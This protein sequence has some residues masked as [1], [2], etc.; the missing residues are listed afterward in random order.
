MR[1]ATSTAVAD[2]P[3]DIETDM[4]PE[5]FKRITDMLAQRQLDCMDRLHARDAC[6]SLTDIE[7]GYDFQGTLQTH[8]P[9]MLAQRQLDLTVC[10]EEVHKPQTNLAAIRCV[11]P[12]PSAFTGRTRSGPRAGSTSV[13]GAARPRQPELGGRC[14]CIRT[15]AARWL[16][17]K[18][19]PGMQILATHLSDSSVDFRAIDY[20][21][22]TPSWWA[23]E[24]HGIGRKRRWPWPITISSSPWWA[25]CSP[26]RLGGR[27]SHPFY[28]AI[29]ASANWL[30]APARLSAQFGRAEHHLVGGGYPVYAQP[31]KE[32]E[33][34]Y[35]QLGP[36]GEILADERWWQQMQ[37]T[38]KWVGRTTGRDDGDGV[39]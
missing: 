28:E 30:A 31:C 25:W 17:S 3:H 34:P 8:F 33:M 32:K 5:R 10:M 12:T 4:T 11:P 21:R 29:S 37:L 14:S 22:P 39:S 7:T 18:A 35:P 20:T 26:Q 6:T 2:Q 9:D 1:Q 13:Q 24:K 38:R 15:S 16:N 36:A 23:R 27:R 19:Q